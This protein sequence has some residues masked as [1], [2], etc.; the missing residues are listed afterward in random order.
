MNLL[1]SCKKS[2]SLIS[3]PANARILPNVSWSEFS[4]WCSPKSM[5]TFPVLQYLS[6]SNLPYQLFSLPRLRVVDSWTEPM[7]KLR[8]EI[9]ELCKVEMDRGCN[10]CAKVAP[11][12]I[13]HCDIKCA[14]HRNVCLDCQYNPYVLTCDATKLGMFFKNVYVIK[15]P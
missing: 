1:K 7:G 4:S 13:V 11:F 5:I 12:Y 2:T 10:E 6:C 15:L 3:H 14:C 9:P 8:K